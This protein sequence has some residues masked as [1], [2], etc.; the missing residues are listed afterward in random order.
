MPTFSFRASD[1]VAVHVHQ[2]RGNPPARAV[3]ML[4]HG[5]SEHAGRYAEFGEAL[6]ARGIDLYA[7]DLRGHGVTGTRQGVLGHFAAHNGWHRVLA[8]LR[9][10]EQLIRER[11]PNTP[12]L[13]FGHSMG[14]YLAQAYLMHHGDGFAGAVLSG[15]NYQPVA[16][17][18]LGQQVARLECWRQG[19]TG[20]SAVLEALTFGSFNRAF[21]PA[22]THHDWLSR[23]PAEVDAYL[24]DP[25]CGI[26][27]TNQL[28][29]DLFG[30]LQEITPVANL[31]R[32][33]HDLPLLV[34]GGERDPVSAGRRQLDLADALRR[35]G[36]LQINTQLYPD[37]R[38]ELLHETHRAEVIAYLLDWLEA[39]LATQQSRHA[40]EIT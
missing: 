25:L 32:I 29:V 23:D 11:H 40:K 30:G 22:R 1:E 31:A 27:C 26:R 24:A 9:E 21:R 16:L 10:L 36:L 33:P 28:W 35:A 38:H 34:I 4:I 2:W 19:P 12:L 15:S 5:M 14:S 8:D 7:P 18:R 13:L 17:Y 6:A 39:A 3:L 20:R 37:A